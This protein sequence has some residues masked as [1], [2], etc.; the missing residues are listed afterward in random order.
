MGQARALLDKEWIAFPNDKRG[1]LLLYLTYQA[2][3][4]SREHLALLFWP[5]ISDKEARRNLRQLIVR[6]KKLSIATLL[7]I[8]TDRLSISC[9]T[10]VHAF[11][12][13]MAKQDW[14]EAVQLYKGNLG[15]SLNITAGEFTNWLELE[16][17]MLQAT[18]YEALSK[19]SFKFESQR[20]YT[21]AARYLSMLLVQNS[22]AE[23]IVQRYMRAAYLAGQ[24]DRALR[25]Y[26]SFVQRLEEEL[27]INPLQDT[28][29]LY[30][31]INSATPLEGSVS[32]PIKPS[33]PLTVL[34]PP[35]M[36]GREKELAELNQA[37]SIIVLVAAEAGMG[38]TRLMQEAAPEA[39]FFKCHE[40][41]QNVPYHP[42]PTVIREGANKGFP[43]PE[44]YGYQQALARLVP[45]LLPEI[46]PTVD[47]EDA[48]LRLLEALSCYFAGLDLASRFH[49]I[50]DDLQ[51]ADS[52]T[53]EL[54]SYLAEQGKFRLL[55]GYRIHELSNPLITLLSSFK[56]SGQATLVEL[57]PLSLAA[58]RSLL[59]NLMGTNLMGSQVGP[60]RFA[61]WLHKTTGGNPM[62]ILET[63]KSLFESKILRAS[64]QSWHTHLDAVTMDYA[65]LQVPTIVFDVIQRRYRALPEASQRALQ[66][67]AVL[68]EAFSSKHISQLSSLSEWASLDALEAAEAAGL[69]QQDQFS[70]D[71]VRESL[72]ASLSESRK[73][74]SH[75]KVLNMLKKDAGVSSAVLARHALAAAH[76]EDAIAYSL[77]AGDEAMNISAFRDANTH[78]QQ[79]LELIPPNNKKDLRKTHEGLGDTFLALGESGA[80]ADAFEKAQKALGN[81]IVDYARLLRKYARTLFDLRLEE[82]GLEKVKAAQNKLE[83]VAESKRNPKWWQEWINL[84][85]L[86]IGRAYSTAQVD[87]LETYI[88]E[89][90][91]LIHHYG[92]LR[93]R[94]ELSRSQVLL[95][96]RQERFNLSE[97]TLEQVRTTFGLAQK[98]KDP[99]TIARDQFGLGFTA[100]WAR[101]VELAKNHLTTSLHLARKLESKVLETQSLAYLSVCFRFLQNEEATKNYSLLGLDLARR[102]N[103]QSYIGVSFANQ[104]WLAL[105]Q[106]N[107]AEATTLAQDALKIW[108]AMDSFPFH[109]LSIF[110]L[111]ACRHYQKDLSECVGLSQRL[112]S[113]L[114]MQL[115]AKLEQTLYQLAEEP[116][117]AL[118]KTCLNI[119][120]EYRYI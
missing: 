111:L 12:N 103:I 57:L 55:V 117:L 29:E 78:Y 30:K 45:D 1:A 9:D 21:E 41:L 98:T 66:F 37:K 61:T 83:Q 99:W 35:R 60:E 58:V 104:A 92:T 5:D 39:L 8:K 95:Y 114:Q 70:H 28:A 43:L 79:A 108:Q 96:S 15:E 44:L 10:D 27:G 33:I 38:K 67:A 113:S 97:K 36:I 25:S 86:R 48:K 64:A 71:L 89:V 59:A 112:F 77:Q 4:V 17:Q 23:D 62:F 40:G 72:Y 51:W 50:F 105:K 19:L 20:N 22:L 85:L 63:L 81:E 34:R 52:A 120:K 106:G 47:F 3:W 18:Y 119:A 76:D 14:L 11:S 46:K 91:P 26:K 87:A 2:D 118:L 101:D 82:Q 115:P 54:V 49:F 102:Q 107:Y 56:N 13:A 31:L 116:S 53:L 94:C 16:R 6:I 73:R 93:Q 7:T 90:I 75:A 68:G 100:L 42:L 65:E 88:N 80:A 74:L 110:P 24:R 69:I 84:A 109:W 32:E